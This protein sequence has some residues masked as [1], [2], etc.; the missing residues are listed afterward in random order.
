M[1][2]FGLFPTL[3]A[4][5]LFLV[6]SVHAENTPAAAAPVAPAASPVPAPA[7][8]PKL[9][10]KDAALLKR[11]DKNGDGKLDEDEL[12]A[13]HEAMR[14]E[15]MARTEGL[16]Q[17]AREKILERFDTNHDGRLD[18]DERAVM[19]K[20]LA[21]GQAAFR[22]RLMERFDTNHDGKL[23]Q[24]ER[25]AARRAFEQFLGSVE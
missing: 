15:Q 24:T 10:E 1:K 21:D 5:T 11:Y 7:P 16:P 25:A 4:A 9:S 14:D 20:T 2:G 8:A 6:G 19:R 23:D 17:P 3:A 22:A 12:A 18:D 13:A